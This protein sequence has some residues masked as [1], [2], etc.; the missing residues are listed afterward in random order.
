MHS[1]KVCGGYVKQLIV[2]IWVNYIYKEANI[3]SETC[4]GTYCIYFK[5]YYG[6]PRL[7]GIRSVAEF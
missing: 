1:I 3:K 5:Y 7:Q 4:T 6:I 2:K